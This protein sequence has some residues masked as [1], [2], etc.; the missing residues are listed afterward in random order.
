MIIKKYCNWVGWRLKYLL[1]FPSSVKGELKAAACKDREFAVFG[2]SLIF[3]PKVPFGGLS[4]FKNIFKSS[5]DFLIL[6]DLCKVRLFGQLKVQN[7]ARER[8]TAKC[9]K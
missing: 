8:S 7:N 6:R 2:E 3:G 4:I 5:S 9:L 1:G